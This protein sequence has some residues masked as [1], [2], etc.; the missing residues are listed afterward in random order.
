MLS[1]KEY[2]VKLWITQSDT[3]KRIKGKLLRQETFYDSSSVASLIA[4]CFP[5]QIP[6]IHRVQLH[7]P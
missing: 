4:A 1:T 6:N 2:G 5:P 3:A 7:S